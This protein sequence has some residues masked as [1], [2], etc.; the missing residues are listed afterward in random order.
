M[1]N[2]NIYIYKLYTLHIIDNGCI[3]VNLLKLL[4]LLCR[5]NY[6][7]YC[8]AKKQDINFCYIILIIKPIMNKFMNIKN[9]L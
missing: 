6:Y 3:F 7:N 8:V 4:L 5:Y 2:R 1:N 9:L